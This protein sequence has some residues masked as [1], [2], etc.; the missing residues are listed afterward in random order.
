MKKK[1]AALL[2]KW[3]KFTTKNTP[4]CDKLGHN[5]WGDKYSMIGF[6]IS[7]SIIKIF[8][9]DGVISASMVLIPFIF[10]FIP[11]YAKEWSD[12]HG[13]GNKDGKDLLATIIPSLKYMLIIA[14]YLMQ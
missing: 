14:A 10:A 8:S 11:A 7:L 13:H 12:G 9:L 3:A 4:A 6:I 5:F 2:A 1:I